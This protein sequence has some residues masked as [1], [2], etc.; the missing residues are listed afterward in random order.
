MINERG[1]IPT[2]ARQEF[3]FASYAGVILF[4]PDLALFNKKQSST[5]WLSPR[6]RPIIERYAEHSQSVFPTTS[7]Y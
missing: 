6:I 3:H 1:R 4:T 2:A 7:L 5:N